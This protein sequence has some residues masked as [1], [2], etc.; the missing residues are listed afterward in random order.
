M[1]AEP[2]IPNSPLRTKAQAA[3]FTGIPAA[4]LSWYRH[5]GIGPKSA[6]IGGRVMYRQEDLD[7]WIEEAFQSGK[8]S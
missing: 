1:T 4:T 8:A 6:L 5:K 3:E 7:A 2:G